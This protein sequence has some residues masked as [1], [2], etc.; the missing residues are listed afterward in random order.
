MKELIDFFYKFFRIFRYY[1]FR[2]IHFSSASLTVLRTMPPAPQ[3]KNTNIKG[4]AALK[5][6]S[7]PFFVYGRGAAEDGFLPVC[8]FRSNLTTTS[9]YHRYGTMFQIIHSSIR[10]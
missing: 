8:Y 1:F 10:M 4:T 9:R 6:C 3:R 7:G 5:L 2:Y